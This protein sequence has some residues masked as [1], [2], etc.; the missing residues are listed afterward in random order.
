[1][2]TVNTIC[3][4]FDQTRAN[5]LRAMYE[6]AINEQQDAFMFEEQT[7]FTAFASYLLLF[8]S[9]NGLHAAYTRPT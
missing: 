7:W 3:G 4:D 6:K 2:R 1:M 8:L 5:A 9:N